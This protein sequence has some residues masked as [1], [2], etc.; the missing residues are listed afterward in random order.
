MDSS[1]DGSREEERI[2][3]LAPDLDPDVL[4]LTPVEGFLLSR[5]DGSTSWRTLCHIGGLSPLEVDRALERFEAQGVIVV[6]KEKPKARA[7]G[8]ERAPAPPPK[9]AVPKGEV[10][11]RLGISVELQRRILEFEQQLERPY[12]ELLGVERNADTKEIKRA[13]FRLSREY[14]PDRYFR[15][16]IGHFGA[17]LERIFRKVAEAYELLSD[18]TTRAEIERSLASMPGPAE[19]E[20]RSVA[21][22]GPGERV[23]PQPR[24][25]RVPDRMQNLERL[26]S[27]FKIPPKL[28]AERR[29]KARQ[30]FQAARVSAHEGRYLE[31]AQ[32]MR[33]AIAFDPWEQQYKTG[34]SDIQ[35]RVHAARAEE[36]LRQAGDASAQ[37]EALHLLEEAL[38]YRPC[39]VETLK[40]AVALCV[41]LRELE[42]A[43]E[44][45]EQLVE[46][47]PEVAAHL[48]KLAGVLRRQGVREKAAMALERAAKLDARD[49]DV[50]AER[51]QQTRSRLRPGGTA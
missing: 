22:A 2:P 5:I 44:Y 26:R 4:E 41:D 23:G 21:P 31:A 13:Y 51:L 18:P 12:H 46:I 50:K 42:K 20:Y 48:A 1:G 3:R 25:Y 28:L 49:P 30:L 8:E 39:D 37:G 35:G 29:I 7:R 15:R 27:R 36:L 33:L 38:H 47:E 6:E 24:G 17:R 19:G 9:P 34:F 16:Q 40:R 10:D 11:A 45:A 32:S 43:R 14:H